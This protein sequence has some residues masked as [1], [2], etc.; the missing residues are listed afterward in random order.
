MGL[1][2]SP[3]TYTL[4]HATRLYLFCFYNPRHGTH[5]RN[6][7]TATSIWWKRSKPLKLRNC[8]CEGWPEAEDEAEEEEAMAVMNCVVVGWCYLGGRGVRWWWYAV[9]S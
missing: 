8:C 6:R 4:P 7:S 5:R 2:L 1:A 9:F 3:H